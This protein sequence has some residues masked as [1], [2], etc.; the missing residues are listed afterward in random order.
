MTINPKNLAA[1]LIFLP[2]LAT[3]SCKEEPSEPKP[4][5]EVSHVA[6]PLEIPYEEYSPTPCKWSRD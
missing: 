5:P 3:T 2:L 1:S 6:Y 4:L